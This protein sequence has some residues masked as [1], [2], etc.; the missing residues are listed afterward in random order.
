MTEETKPVEI[1]Q[2]ADTTPLPDKIIV[3]RILWLFA[4]KNGAS[5]DELDYGGQW[6]DGEVK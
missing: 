3:D 2:I 4:P 6:N 5:F 1:V